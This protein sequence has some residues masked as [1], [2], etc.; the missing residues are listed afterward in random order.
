MPVN[1]I[2]PKLFQINQGEKLFLLGVKLAFIPCH[3]KCRQSEH[4][5][6]VVYSTV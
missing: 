6:G 1:Y 2:T 3:K 5:K 4:R